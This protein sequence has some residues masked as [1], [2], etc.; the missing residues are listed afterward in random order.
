MNAQGKDSNCIA[1][2]AD[3][4]HPVAS[5]DMRLQFDPAGMIHWP[6]SEDLSFELMRLLGLAQ[7]GGSRIS[8]CLLAAS[9]IDARDNDSWHREWRRMADVSNERANAALKRGHLP[10]AQSNWLRAISYYQTCALDLDP[11][12]TRRHA[13][14]STMRAC[15][16]RYLEH[17]TPAGE[18]V[19]IP[20]LDGHALEGYFLPA[21]AGSGNTPVVVCMGEPGHRKEEHL[22]KGERYAR[23]RGMSLL[24]V[25]LFGSG[26]GAQFEKIVGR[27]D[28]E[29][30]V[31]HVMDYLTTRDDIDARRIAI[32]GDGSGSSFVAR[33]VALDRRFAAAVCDGGIWDLHERAF[34]MNRFASRKADRAATSGYGRLTQN[35]ACPVLITLG[36]R[37]WLE[38]DR[39]AELFDRLRAD[40]RDITLKI[41]QAPETAA[42]QAHADNPTLASEFIF[43]WLADRLGSASR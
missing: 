27:P 41:F 20:W 26:S 15:A 30:A 19:E 31:G 6:G 2:M 23:D 11:A 43:D 39:V 17:L 25:D 24:A 22:C 10:T 34:L 5:I 32:L 12:D 14:L 36:A 3:V 13:A 16:H 33:G 38:A 35:L 18:V 9:R 28:L 29:T 21:P 8:E 4:A 42:A 40:D 7:E 37:G 1:L